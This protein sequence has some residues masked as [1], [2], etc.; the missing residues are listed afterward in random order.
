MSAFKPSKSAI[1][2]PLI[3]LVGLCGYLFYKNKQLS[4]KVEQFR[5]TSEDEGDLVQRQRQL[6][7]ADSL[8]IRGEYR[9]AIQEYHELSDDPDF[10]T[11]FRLVAAKRLQ[12]MEQRTRELESPQRTKDSIS[13]TLETVPQAQRTI[14]SLNF[15]LEKSRRQ[16]QNIKNQVRNRVYGE[17][18]TFTSGKGNKLHYVGE[19]KHKKATGY[20]IAILDSGSRYEG[21]WL[22]NERHGKGVFYWIDGEHYEGEYK[23]DQRSG[24][25]T[26]YWTSGEKFTG[27][28]ENDMRNGYGIF[29]GKDG[30]VI[31]KGYW[32]DDQLTKEEN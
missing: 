3:L 20:G 2:L 18:I 23:N 10:S 25:G 29:Y 26:Y 4:T 28:W 9:R 17:Y 32:E 31:T 12:Q 16:L 21:E 1:L 19:V 30:N 14:D 5:M 24:M 13:T 27:H 15:A 7:T 6:S 8:L 22:N 11:E